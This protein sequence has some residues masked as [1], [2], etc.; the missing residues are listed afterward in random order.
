MDPIQDINLHL[1]P[2]REKLFNH[3]LYSAIKQI[4]HVQVFM[5]HHVFAVW[6]FMSLLKSLQSDLT[7]VQL[8]WKP[9]GTPNTRFL[10][11]EIVC[12][13]ESD[14]NLEGLRASHFEMY[15]DAMRAVHANTTVIAAFI[16]HLNNHQFDLNQ[17]EKLIPKA[18][19]PFVNNT[20]TT[21]FTAPTHVK[22]GVFTFGREDLIP[23]MFIS[24]VKEFNQQFQGKFDQ[25]IY[26]LERHIE[27]DG[28]HHSNLAIEMTA[29]LC[30]DDQSKW[31]EVKIAAE[32]ALLQRIQLWDYI[33][34]SIQ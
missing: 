20:L 31:N 1:A 16:D 29:S 3:P 9:V 26:Y 10:I 28:S 4:E 19:F 27:V 8:P 11:N 6:D 22:A 7:C 14:I 24:M 32:Q 30:G 12:G 15:L 23:G 5:E 34:L 25:F 21:A 18:V 2:L 13:E 17:L 33:Q